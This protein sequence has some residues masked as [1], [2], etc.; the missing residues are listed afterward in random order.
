MEHYAIKLCY[1]LA[2]VE[3]LVRYRRTT[4]VH[5][6]KL[7]GFAELIDQWLVSRILPDGTRQRAR[8]LSGFLSHYLLR[9]R[10]GRPGKGNDKMR[11]QGHNNALR[12]ET[13][14][15]ARCG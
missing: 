4:Q 6:P 14:S 3:I 8:L 7:D 11:F 15:A 10:Y 9:D 2:Q 12:T 13:M 1:Q 5:R